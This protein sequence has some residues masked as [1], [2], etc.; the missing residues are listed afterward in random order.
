MTTPPAA[1]AVIHG[2]VWDARITRDPRDA[3]KAAQAVI[4]ALERD[5]W[6]ITA[7]RPENGPQ[8]AT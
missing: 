7:T 3:D 1:A 8:T 6:T 5:G 4:H 2:A